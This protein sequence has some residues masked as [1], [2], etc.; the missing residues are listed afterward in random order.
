MYT[1]PQANLQI[2]EIVRLATSYIPSSKLDEFEKDLQDYYSSIQIRTVPHRN[3]GQNLVYYL[4]PSHIQICRED[5]DWEEALRLSCRPLLMEDSIT[6]E[7][8]E[9]IVEDQRNRG[10]M[11][12]LADGLVLAHAAIEKGVKQLDVALCTFKHPVTFLNGKQARIIIVLCAED[13]TKHIRILNDVLNIFSK[14]KSI[15]Q[16]AALES[17]EDIQSYIRAHTQENED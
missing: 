7:Y 16:L 9:A 3:F 17:S 4:K 2:Q 11:M 13:Q 1:E 8:V 10:L 12:F 14:K 15:E 5:C 6:Q